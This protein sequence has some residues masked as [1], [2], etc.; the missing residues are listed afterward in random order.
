MCSKAGSQYQHIADNIRASQH[1]PDPVN[2]ILLQSEAVSV[3]QKLVLPSQSGT[4]A[5][6]IDLGQVDG[7]SVGKLGSYELRPGTF[8]YIG[9]AH[10]PGGLAGRIKRHMRPASQKRRHWHIDWLLESA[11]L[12]QIW[13]VQSPQSLECAW[14]QTISQIAE[15]PIPWIWILGL[16]LCKPSLHVA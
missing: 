10:G 1:L 7:L 12:Q 16:L 14:S 4:Y 6:L 15:S 8:C 3:M 13:W 11:S 5:L 9:S 2:H